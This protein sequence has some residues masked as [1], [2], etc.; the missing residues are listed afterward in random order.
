MK[1]RAFGISRSFTQGALVIA[2]MLTGCSTPV[3]SPADETSGFTGY[4]GYVEIYTETVASFP[5]TMPEGV[6]FPSSPPELGG[7]IG[8][9]NGIA[10]AY[11]F[12]QCAWEDA[13]L[14]T[15][16]PETKSEAMLQLRRV[17]ETV[18]ASQYLED[19]D[20]IWLQVLAE[21]ELGDPSALREFYENGCSYY[22]E[23]QSQG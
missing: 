8:K 15:T 5:E 4:E 22:R 11:F 23:Q 7:S 16:D 20:D 9:G 14:K 2:L 13:Y 19:P 21:A 1:E 10:A 18:W 17:P 6:N 3:T 12:W